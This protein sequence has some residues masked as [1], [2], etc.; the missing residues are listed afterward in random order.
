MINYLVFRLEEDL[1][2]FW[3]SHQENDWS[4][5]FEAVD[6]FSA[7][8]SLASYV[9]HSKMIQIHHQYMHTYHFL[10]KYQWLQNSIIGTT[11]NTF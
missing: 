6:P 8:G 4:H 3:Q 11:K 7:L 1:I 5:I 9:H 2:I 10:I